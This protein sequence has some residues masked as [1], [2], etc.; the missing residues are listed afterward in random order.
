MAKKRAAK[1]KRVIKRRASANALEQE[2]R[3]EVAR[4]LPK[5]EVG[6]VVQVPSIMKE[7]M[8][9]IC[10]CAEAVRQLSNAIEKVNHPVRIESCHFQNCEMGMTVKGME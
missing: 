8:Q 9:A 3:E 1:K 10:D 4:Q 2:I 5:A 6:A 7:K